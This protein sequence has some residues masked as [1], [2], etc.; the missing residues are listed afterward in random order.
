MAALITPNKLEAELLLALQGTTQK[1]ETLDDM[2]NA[3]ELFLWSVGSNAVLL[4]GGHVIATMRDVII[5]SAK[6]PDIQIIK[7]GLYE[8]NMEILLASH[9]DYSQSELVIDI[10]HQVSGERTLFVHP[11]INSSS[12]HGARCT[13]S[14]AIAC[15]IALDCKCKYTISNI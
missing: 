10:L 1:I 3:T 4:K 7:H 9:Q 12:T 2:L 14:S 13:L 5:M 8:D 6:K 11:R 15:G